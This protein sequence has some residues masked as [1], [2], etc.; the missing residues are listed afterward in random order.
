M[1]DVLAWESKESKVGH[2]L[3]NQLNDKELA[4]IN[5][6]DCISNG[7]YMRKGVSDIVC[8]GNA[9]TARFYSS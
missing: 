7:G 8:A 1:S 6:A 2:L 5:E 4:V 3:H 9:V